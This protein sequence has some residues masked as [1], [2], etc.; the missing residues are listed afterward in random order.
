M[1]A[2]E[3]ALKLVQVTLFAWLLLGNETCDND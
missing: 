3:L 1:A 2:D